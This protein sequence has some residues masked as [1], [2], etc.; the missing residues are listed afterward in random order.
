ED[1]LTGTR[2]PVASAYLT[3]VSLDPQARVPRAVPQVVPETVEEKR[4]FDAA[5]GRRDYRLKT[6]GLG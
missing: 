2:K 4:R 6:R 5:K 3:F 1:R